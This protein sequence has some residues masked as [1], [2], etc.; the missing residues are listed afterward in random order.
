LSYNSPKLW[1]FR[2]RDPTALAAWWEI[3]KILTKWGSP[4]R[5]LNF[6]QYLISDP[7]HFELRKIAFEFRNAFA[8]L[9]QLVVTIF[10]RVDN[11]FISRM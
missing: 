11:L 3:P 7:S 6:A 1:L 5:T 8:N 9:V 10:Y 2:K 4:L